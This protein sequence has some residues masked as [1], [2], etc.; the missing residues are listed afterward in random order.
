MYLALVPKHFFNFF[1]KKTVPV[2]NSSP[3]LLPITLKGHDF[4]CKIVYMDN[5]RSIIEECLEKHPCNVEYR[6]NEPMVNHTTFKVGGPSDCWVKPLDEDSFDFTT[7]L[8]NALKINQIPLFILGAGANI[9]VSDRGIRGFVLD[10]GGWNGEVGKKKEERGIILEFYAGTKLDDA[11][12]IA[13][14]IGLSGIE[15]LA[16]MPGSLGGALWMN[17]RAYNREM[18]DVVIE[19]EIFDLAS[20]QIIRRKVKTTKTEFSYK[21]SPFQ[22]FPCLILSISL[23]LQKHYETEIRSEMENYCKDRQAKGHYLFPSAGSAFKNNRDFGK[24]TGQI[25]DELGLKGYNIGGAQIAPFHGNIIINTD[26]ATAQDIHS[27]IGFIQVKVKE[28]T[29][30]KLEPEILFVGDW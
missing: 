14:S 7:S 17:A 22:N 20:P 9:V 3:K 11:A 10:T 8:I 16:G 27:L 26:A 5:F 19:C 21:H 15:F 12:E 13:A 30:L 18:A 4:H 6:F 24:P 29:G 28:K 25:I 1:L 2:T 23:E